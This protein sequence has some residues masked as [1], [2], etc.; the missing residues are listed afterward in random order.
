MRV[1]FEGKSGIQNSFSQ[2][3]DILYIL[4]FDPGTRKNFDKAI[5]DRPAGALYKLIRKANI[6]MI[7]A[8]QNEQV[9]VFH[10]DVNSKD[11]PDVA[12]PDFEN[13]LR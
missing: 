6:N 2:L 5:F 1:L 10:P 9:G 3:H 11:V 12:V 8:I 13:A 4:Y 7:H